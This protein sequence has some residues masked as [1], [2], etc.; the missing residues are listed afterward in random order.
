MNRV[1]VC[2][3]TSLYSTSPLYFS[4]ALYTKEDLAIAPGGDSSTT[5]CNINNFVPASSAIDKASV[6]AAIPY[7]RTVRFFLL[8]SL[9]QE[10]NLMA[11]IPIMMVADMEL[12]A[13]TKVVKNIVLLVV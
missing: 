1:V 3:F 11:I 2:S 12:T 9:Y 10:K 5:T 4:E 6:K 8:L 7:S 13:K